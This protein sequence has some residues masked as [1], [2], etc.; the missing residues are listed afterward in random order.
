MWLAC[1]RLRMLRAQGLVALRKLG[2]FFVHIA[3]KGARAIAVVDIAA[4]L[5]GTVWL[6]PGGNVS[7]NHGNRAGK[8]QIEGLAAVEHRTGTTRLLSAQFVFREPLDKVHDILH[9]NAT[10]GVGPARLAKQ[11][12]H[13]RVVHVDD[14]GV[15]HV[16]AH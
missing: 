15:R 3:S 5:D 10:C 12:L 9:P 7:E 1:L 4:E 14:V 13:G 8:F 16:D 6:A 2:F 11:L